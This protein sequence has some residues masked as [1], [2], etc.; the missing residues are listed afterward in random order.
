MAKKVTEKP[1]YYKH[2][3]SWVIRLPDEY[4]EAMEKLCAI[5]MRDM[6]VEAQR[7]LAAHFVAEGIEFTA[8][9][10]GRR[11]GRPRKTA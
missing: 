9:P 4:R 5:T 11:S 6:T 2:R 8:P 7:A 10:P 1:A 3:D